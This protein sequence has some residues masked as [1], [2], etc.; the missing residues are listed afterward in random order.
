MHNQIDPE[1]FRTEIEKHF[2]KKDAKAVIEKLPHFATEYE[3]WYSESIAVLRQLLP[4]R[5]AHFVSFYEKPKARKSVEY[6]NYVIQDFLQNLTVTRGDGHKMV[7]P[8][9]AIRQFQQQHAILKAAQARFKSSLFEIRQLVQADLFDTEIDAAR[10]LAK[11]NFLRAAGAVAG[12]VLERHLS[13]VC[14]DHGIQIRK[15][16]PSIAD[17]NDLLKTEG[18][19]EIAQWRH[20]QMLG[21]IR[22]SCDHQKAAEPTAEQIEDLI[23]GA[24]KILKTLA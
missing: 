21:D 7:G 1:H 16:H 12:V 22:N 24:N 4:D 13:Q 9:A 19:I 18:V 11:N 2:G 6:G 17:F 5:L 8:S 15:K 23:S 20:V 3:A 14:Q 10:E